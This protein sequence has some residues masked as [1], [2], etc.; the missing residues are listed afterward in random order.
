MI[1]EKKIEDII[2]LV[3]EYIDVEVNTG[4]FSDAEPDLETFPFISNKDKEFVKKKIK[5]I[6][7]E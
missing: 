2:E 1:E 7:N 5:E 4:W 3:L 6:L